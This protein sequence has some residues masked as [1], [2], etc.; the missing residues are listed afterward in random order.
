MENIK[1]SNSPALSFLSKELNAPYNSKA[2][3][4]I[5]Q[6]TAW[7]AMEDYE[8]FH[9]RQT[10]SGAKLTIEQLD[11]AKRLCADDA[12]LCE[13]VEVNAGESEKK[14]KGVRDL[15]QKNRFTVMY[16]KQLEMMAA[17]GTVGAYIRLDNAILYDDGIVRDGDIKINYVSASSIIPITVENEEV[18]ECAFIG[19]DYQSGKKIQTLV[20]FRL[21]E[22]K[23]YTAGSYYF[24][25]NK[26]L[27]DK[28]TTLQLGEVKP[29]AIMRTA[30]VNSLSGM[31]G[32]GFPKL[33][34]AIPFLK[35]IDLCYAILYGDL[36]KGQKLLFINELLA[37]IQKDKNGKAFLTPKQK[38]LFILMG[39]KL[40]VDKDLIYEY[41]PEIRIQAIK[42]TFQLC[43][44][45]LS[46]MFG[47]GSKK[48]TLESGEIKTATEYIGQRQDAM[49][50]LNRQRQEAKDYITNIVNALIW[51]HNQFSNEG[52]WISDD[53]ICIE[54]D[55]SYITDKQ[56]EMD[57][58]RADAQAFPEVK[59]FLIQ[60]IMRRL[61]CERDE[62]IK[63]I[64]I[65]DLDTEA[66][67]ED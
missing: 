19:S 51:F 40:P 36:D 65:D 8:S 34:K 3:A 7:Y 2:M 33:L 45:M 13:L 10:V 54:F 37:D 1:E 64:E 59:E 60:Y 66:E 12:N 61:N 9:E 53:E 47:F 42:D 52:P 20:V 41:N 48:Y 21:G 28:R 56:T 57:A 22:D 27:S 11:F 38:E 16:R 14:F 26:E 35:A 50:E 63:Y 30:E 25:E 67:Q 18:V 31:Q 15:L 6:C 43:L 49:Q 17:T 44:S 24:D 39:E 58:W 46:T 29:F 4:L 32:Y 55:D 5:T 23:K 62:A